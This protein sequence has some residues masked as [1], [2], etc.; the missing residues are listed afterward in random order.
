MYLK[1]EFKNLMFE[2]VFS[3]LFEKKIIQKTNTFQII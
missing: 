1:I 2:K 3:K